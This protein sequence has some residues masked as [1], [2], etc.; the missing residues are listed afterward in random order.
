MRK[1]ADLWPGDVVVA[2]K[3]GMMFGIPRRVQAI[4]VVEDAA[5]DPVR[6]DLMRIEFAD[7]SVIARETEDAPPS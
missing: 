7:F 3:P 5:P 4:E 6:G 1:V 2:R